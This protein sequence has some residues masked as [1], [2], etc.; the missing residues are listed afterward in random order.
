M[1][2]HWQRIGQS[3]FLEKYSTYACEI[4]LLVCQFEWQLLWQAVGSIAVNIQN[5][6]YV[7]RIRWRCCEHHNVVYSIYIQSV[8]IVR[9]AFHELWQVISIQVNCD[10]Q[11]L[12]WCS[13]VSLNIGG[14]WNRLHNNSYTS[15]DC[16]SFLTIATYGS[17]CT[18]VS[19]FFFACCALLWAR[20][21]IGCSG[22]CSSS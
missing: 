14:H 10:F 19:L 18:M 1:T 20:I 5:R 7:D 17:L 3:L 15:T 4:L 16:W 21:L 13:Q 22:S 8:T 11:S 12:K 9:I 2:E 6:L